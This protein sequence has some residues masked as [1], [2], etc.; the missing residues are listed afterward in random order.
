MP[1]QVQVQAVDANDRYLIFGR[2]VQGQ[3]HETV[4]VWVFL[5]VDYL[6][7]SCSL[8]DQNSLADPTDWITL[9]PL[10]SREDHAE[11][12]R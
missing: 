1:E 2:V 3:A 5:V 11:P 6:S 4:A 10:E 8:A 12:R 9:Q 7:R